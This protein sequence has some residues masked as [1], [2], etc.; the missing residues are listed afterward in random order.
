MSRICRILS[1]TEDQDKSGDMVVRVAT[2]IFDEDRWEQLYC[3]DK[4]D[5]YYHL[6]PRETITKKEVGTHLISLCCSEEPEE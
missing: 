3:K 1:L 2:N 6:V 5:E 4:G